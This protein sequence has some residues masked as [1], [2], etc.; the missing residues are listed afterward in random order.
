MDRNIMNIKKGIREKRNA[1][2]N[3]Y[4]NGH[5]KVTDESSWILGFERCLKIGAEVLEFSEEVIRRAI[6]I[7]IDYHKR[8][9]SSGKSRIV[10]AGACLYIA[11]ILEK[12]KRAQRTVAD[13]LDITEPALRKR[14]HNIVESL[15]IEQS[16]EDGIDDYNKM[17]P[18]EGGPGVKV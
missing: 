8:G 15:K 5:R 17:H 2:L 1:E 4:L 14:F 3:K 16:I 13:A 18:S 6:M 10:I 7:G 12:D 11:A 9:F